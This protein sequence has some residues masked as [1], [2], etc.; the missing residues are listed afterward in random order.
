MPYLSPPRRR[1]R[2]A[3]LAREPARFPHRLRPA[4]ERRA[5]EH[6][7]LRDLRGRAPRGVRDNGFRALA[8]PD[9]IR[10][11]LA[12]EPERRL[13][14]PR[15]SRFVSGGEERVVGHAHRGHVEYRAEVEREAG[16]AWMILAGA[17]NED[18][19]R[20][21]RES[22]H[23]GFEDGPFAEREQ[24]R[25]KWC[26][27]PPDESGR[28]DDLG[29]VLD[30]RCRP[31]DAVASRA[32][33]HY[34]AGADPQRARRRDPRLA[35]RGREPVLLAREVVRRGGAGHGWPGAAR[36]PSP[37]GTAHTGP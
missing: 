19:I 7:L 30:D 15:R 31:A 4:G 2:I 36:A 37:P 28:G 6:D 21:P 14:H 9:A 23:H 16:A 26:L 5:S 17:G 3:Q 22:S 24:P 34:R 10:D 12:S 8:R 32:P 13:C 11:H 20:P 35:G 33:E 27:D 18:D 29:S 1:L 25:L